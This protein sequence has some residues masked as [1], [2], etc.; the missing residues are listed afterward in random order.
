MTSPSLP[1]YARH[2]PRWARPASLSAAERRHAAHLALAGVLLMAL[3]LRLYRLDGSSLWSDEGNTWALVQRSWGQI[4]HDAAVDIHPPGYYWLLKLWSGLFGSSAAAIRSFSALLGTALVG[5]V[6]AVGRRAAPAA[7]VGLGLTAA[8]LAAVNPFQ[9][10][11]SQEARMYMLLAVAGAGLFWA[12]LAWFDREGAGRGVAGPALG[13][14]AAG[15]LGLWTHYSFPILLSAAGLAYLWHWRGLLAAS[16]H[17]T[18]SLTVFTLANLAVVGSFAPWLPTAVARVLAWPKGGVVTAPAEGVRLTLHMLLFGPLHDLPDPIWP[19]LAAAGLLPLLGLTAPARRARGV[20]LGLWLLAPVAL[21]FGLGLFSDAFLKFLLVAS[22]AWLLL[23]AAS[24]DLL[25][26][27]NAG[28]G[29]LIAGA[30][31]L[32]ALTLPAYFAGPNSRDNYAG[33]ARYIAATGDPAT[34]LVILDAP[35]QADVWRYYDPGLPVLALPGRRPP[36]AAATQAALDAAVGGKRQLFALFWATDEAD[37]QR[38]VESRL[39]QHAFRGLESW[40]GNVRFVVYTQPQALTCTE[41]TPPA[42]FGGTFEL[43]AHCQPNLPQTV[44]SGQTALVELRWR[45]SAPLPVRYKVS[46]QLLDARRQV[47]AQHDAAPAGGSR[48]TD[49]WAAGEVVGDNHG[50]TIPPGTPPGPYTLIVAVYDEAGGARLITSGGDAY[51]LGQ[52]EVARPMQPVP[53]G[54]APIRVRVGRSLGPVT[55][56]GY[57]LHRK[58]FSHA[59]QTPLQPGDLVHITLLWQA[60]DPLPAAW[61]ADLRFSLRLG[62]QTLTAPLAGEAYPTGQ[63]QAGELVRGEFDLPFDGSDDRP[64]L[65]VDGDALRLQRLPR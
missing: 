23:I 47:I 60:P 50:L 52:V 8:L 12:L 38:I 51:T 3:A 55:L 30:A 24:P 43:L 10:Y 58:G 61:P 44:A 15:S 62:S 20:A 48:P 1:N 39:D 25:P 53:A 57:D 40:Q 27:P 42:A 9:I 36:D 6:Y 34:D 37:P 29:L 18:R 63:W 46:V 13:F 19:W 33:V 5:M 28:R 54:V 17:P 35:G 56:V 59:P 32:A 16:R 21:M 45:A 22:P 41:L 14:I 26:W 11:Y 49:S 4:A 64:R 7:S 31:L 65:E 2:L